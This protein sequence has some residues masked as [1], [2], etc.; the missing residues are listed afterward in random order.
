MVRRTVT[1]DR[2]LGRALCNIS[3]IVSYFE[4]K[5]SV[6]DP[7]LN[8]RAIKLKIPAGRYTRTKLD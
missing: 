1:R 6:F 5:G 4:N 2:A 7:G 8:A 3:Q